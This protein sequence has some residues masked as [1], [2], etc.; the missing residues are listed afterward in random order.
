[1]STDA[2][3]VCDHVTA[4]YG[5]IS[6][7]DDLSLEVVRGRILGII[8]PNGSGKTTLLNVLS[9]LIIPTGGSVMYQGKNITR[10]SPD[11]RCRMGIART[12]QVP[13]PFHRMSVFENALTAAAFGSGGS[14]QEA[15][16]R[17]RKALLFTN[18]WGKRDLPAGELML[19]DRKRLEIAR[20]VSTNPNL[21]LLDEIAAG[22]T[23]AEVEEIMEIAARLKAEGY[24]I[25]WIEHIIDTMM[26]ATDMLVCMAEG[27]VLVSGTAREVMLSREVE[28]VYLG[29]RENAHAESE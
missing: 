18:L 17:A 7:L 24:T 21:L 2:I 25:V 6:V 9:G 22:L 5:R 26:R 16:D 12:F 15:R 11:A 14:R 27:R 8:G 28:Q 29:K 19:L 23:S 3:L 13:R 10:L 4:G 20:S 1:M